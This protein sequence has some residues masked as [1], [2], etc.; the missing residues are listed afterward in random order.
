MTGRTLL[1]YTST[2]FLC[3]RVPH[4]EHLRQVIDHLQ[5]AG[6]K[7]KPM[8]CHF[9]REE[10]EYLGQLIIPQGLKPNPKLVEAV[11]G[12]PA[13]QN[14]KQL[15]QLL[16]LSSY[17]RHFIPKFAKVAQPL[18]SLTKKD[19]AFEWDTAYQEALQSRL[20]EA[21]VLAYLSF[22]KDFAQKVDAS[23]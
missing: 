7:L 20:T 2:M 17:Y 19:T 12:F 8:K 18:Q 15:R 3:S 14:L 23:I 6:L 21:P 13:P 4:L 10:V 1:Q 5:Q 16:G 22:D 11:R 9:V